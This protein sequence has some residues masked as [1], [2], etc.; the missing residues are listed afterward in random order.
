MKSATERERLIRPRDVS[1]LHVL[2]LGLEM[3]V[4][5]QGRIDG[6]DTHEAQLVAERMLARLRGE[7]H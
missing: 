3:V 7:E 4:N 5:H 2:E 6:Y 1:E